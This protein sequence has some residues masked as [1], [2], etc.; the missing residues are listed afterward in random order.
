MRSLPENADD[1]CRQFIQE[2]HNFIEKK[3]VQIK[4]IFNMDQVPRYFEKT[5]PKSTITT[6]GSREV[7]I[8]KG[9]T[10]HTR[11]T[12]TFGITASGVMLHPHILFCG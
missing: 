10:S 12:V 2:V 7:L 1:I 3:G 8:R 11:F 9:G 4:N 5:E 6:K